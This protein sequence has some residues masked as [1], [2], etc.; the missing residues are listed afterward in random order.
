MIREIFRVVL[1]AGL[2]LGALS[3]P[4]ATVTLTGAANNGNTCTYASATAD[5]NGSITVVCSGGGGG[6]TNPSTQATFFITPSATSTFAGS[7]ISVRV[8][9]LVAAGGAPGSD[10]VTLGLSAG[11]TSPTPTSFSAVNFLASDGNASS[12]LA[13]SVTF[14][15]AGTATF[16]LSGAT[17]TAVPVTVVSAAAACPAFASTD[18]GTL[19][20][21]N[22]GTV[23][24]AP[25][26]TGEKSVGAFRFTVPT[27]GPTAYT[28]SFGTGAA[29]TFRGKDV[30]ISTCPGDFSAK[31]MS[32]AGQCFVY[33][34]SALKGVTINVGSTGCAVSAGSNYY[35]N[36][37]SR[38]AG[39]TMGFQLQ[40]Q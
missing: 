5:A 2:M 24:F 30:A 28:F 19:S 7:T 13:G 26:S 14:A 40:V 11:T 17:A 12:K 31:G 3:A 16:S 22:K 37:R 36:V 1:A 18:L 32:D 20:T 23:S 25:A 39:E 21:G 34:S 8:T 15:A 35:L 9:R 6:N 10:T 4:A 27:P 38:S 29:G 33:N